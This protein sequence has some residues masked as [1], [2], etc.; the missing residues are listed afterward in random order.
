MD[1]IKFHTDCILSLD[2]LNEDNPEDEEEKKKR[3]A[4]NEKMLHEK[5]VR[6]ERK[7]Y[8]AITD[9]MAGANHKTFIKERQAKAETKFVISFGFGFITVMFLGFLTGF[10]A[11][12]YVLE[13]DARSSMIASLFTGIPTLFLEMVLMIFRLTKWEAR[14][15]AEKKRFKID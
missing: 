6:L 9:S 7:K 4:A 5:R 14:K 15:A 8:D 10:M 13:W 3:L 1:V 2:K 11:G 12:F